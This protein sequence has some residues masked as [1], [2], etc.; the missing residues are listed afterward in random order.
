MQQANEPNIMIPS[1]TNALDSTHFFTPISPAEN[2]GG[3]I[4]TDLFH[5]VN[6]E[7]AGMNLSDGPPQFNQSMLVPG[8]G[9][10]QPPSVKDLCKYNFCVH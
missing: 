9:R 7:Q 8:H 3:K 4:I 6:N 1:P 10:P 5:Q 2:T